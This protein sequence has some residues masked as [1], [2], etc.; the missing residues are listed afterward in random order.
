ME[1]S[2]L[3]PS[4]LGQTAQISCASALL[5][6]V[7][8]FRLMAWLPHQGDSHSTVMTF[9]WSN[10]TASYDSRWVIRQ[11]LIL[12]IRDDFLMSG[13]K[14]NTR[15]LLPP[16]NW[17]ESHL[18]SSSSPIST[19]FS[20]NILIASGYSKIRAGSRNLNSSRGY[21]SLTMPISVA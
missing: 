19:P 2:E 14:S 8:N 18:K 16:S 17:K 10:V 21:C 11:K 15:I 13:R 5:Q 3:F 4:F 9:L 6:Q 12:P 20:R 7:Y 1:L